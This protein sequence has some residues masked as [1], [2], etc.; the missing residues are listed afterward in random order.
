MLEE[1]MNTEVTASR[2]PQLVGAHGAALL[3]ME[4]VSS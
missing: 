4:M 3:A 2:Q 1:E